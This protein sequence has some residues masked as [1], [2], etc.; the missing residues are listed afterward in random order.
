MCVNI[1]KFS[2]VSAEYI[3][4]DRAGWSMSKHG[5]IRIEM[6][7]IKYNKYN[8]LMSN[9]CMFVCST[10]VVLLPLSMFCAVL[11]ATATPY[12]WQYVST[13]NNHISFILDSSPH[14]F[15][16]VYAACHRNNVST[17]ATICARIAN[18]NIVSTFSFLRYRNHMLGKCHI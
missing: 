2:F 11:N 4:S 18:E 16:H 13:R 8:V 10:E 3:Y 17:Y 6:I 12:R 1:I 7:N 5:W 14:W 15:E 9:K